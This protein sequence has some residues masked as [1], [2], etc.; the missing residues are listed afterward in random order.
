MKT[1]YLTDRKDPIVEKSFTPR[2]PQEQVLY[3]RLEP[4]L[5]RL[6]GLMRIL[7]VSRDHNSNLWDQLM[8]TFP[9]PE[10]RTSA[11]QHVEDDTEERT[12]ESQH[13]EDDTSED[14]PRHNND[15]QH[16]PTEPSK[17]RVDP[18]RPHSPTTP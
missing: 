9:V 1:N 5:E 3:G 14:W 13:V 15:G 11:S 17:P 10:E 2:N 18:D 4:S 16:Y 7:M 12:S 8:Q 6:T